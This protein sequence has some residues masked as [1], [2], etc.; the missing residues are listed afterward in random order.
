MILQQLFPL[1]APRSQLFGGAG[2]IGE[3]GV[4]KEENNEFM[5][6]AHTTRKPRLFAYG[7]LLQ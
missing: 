3:M 2:E 6:S 5:S 1:R 4:A 7:Q